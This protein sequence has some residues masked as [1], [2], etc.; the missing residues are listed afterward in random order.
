MPDLIAE[1]DAALTR[2]VSDARF[3]R[4]GGLVLTSCLLGRH[5]WTSIREGQRLYPHLFV[6][7]VANS[8]FG[9]S[10]TIGAVRDALRDYTLPPA[11]TNAVPPI[12]IAATSI[13][14]P[15]M[16]RELGHVF[17]DA[18]GMSGLRSRCYAVLADEV[19]V[20]LG[21]RANTTDLQTLADVWDM[22]QV[23]A[24]QN[25]YSEQK[26]RETKAVDHYAVLFAGAQPAWIAE[27]MPLGRFQLGFPARCHFVLGHT[28]QAPYWSRRKGA[29]WEDGLRQ[30]L[31]PTMA[32]VARL[33]GIVD[34][35]DAAW[36]AFTAWATQQ[37][38]DATSWG[39]LL[40]GYGARRPE[41]AA[42]LALLVACAHV[43]SAITLDDWRDALEALVNA[44]AGLPGVL[45]LVGA[46]PQRP[47]EDEVVAW[48]AQHGETRETA[49]RAKM[50]A[51]FETRAIG[52]TLEE[53]VRAGLLI[54]TTPEQISPHR[55]FRARDTTPHVTS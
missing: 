19:G 45:E 9:K 43:H 48:V 16:V 31:D 50:R 29:T 24:K 27:A 15:R 44:E 33:K 4:W 8:G 5:V 13:T 18:K 51:F 11:T 34:W 53:L 22:K 25:V 30:A 52:P 3:R 41:H 7:L 20:L 36:D 42:K 26:G 37:A 55:K 47:R 38:N 28:R 14:L 35:E 32:Q 49:L 12:R 17:P 23:L 6:A 54:C 39:G 21:D 40:E 1:F 46:N 2:V 10:S